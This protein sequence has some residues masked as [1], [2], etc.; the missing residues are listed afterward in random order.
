M[1]RPE[2]SCVICWPR[3]AACSTSTRRSN[4]RARAF[5]SR[6]STAALCASRFSATCLRGTPTNSLPF[7]KTSCCGSWKSSNVPEPVWLSSH[8][9]F[10]W[11]A[12]PGSTG[13]RLPPP[14]SRSQQWR[15]QHQLPFPDFAP[16]RKVCFPRVDPVSAAR[17][18]S[19]QEIALKPARQLVAPISDTR[20]SQP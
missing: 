1:T 10:I 18:L 11:V 20:W 19:R 17:I 5:D 12:I 16:D 2:T 3:Y 8:K 6:I 7:A 13:R 4:P 15:D 14:K 9:P